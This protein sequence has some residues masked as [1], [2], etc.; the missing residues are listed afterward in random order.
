MKMAVEAE[1]YSQGLVST[2]APGGAASLTNPS[3][4]TVAAGSKASLAAHY[5]ASDGNW[6]AVLETLAAIAGVVVVDMGEIGQESAY[7]RLDLSMTSVDDAPDGKTAQE[8]IYGFRFF[9]KADA[10]ADGDPTVIVV[11]EKLFTGLTYTF[12]TAPNLAAYSPQV[13]GA[14]QSLAKSVADPATLG[15]GRYLAATGGAVDIKTYPAVG[16][17]SSPAGYTLYDR[18]PWR[19]FIRAC[20]KGASGPV[21]GFYPTHARWR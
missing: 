17:T 18:G 2:V 20:A 8:D 21:A 13:L 4:I 10:G 19:G 14:V 6:G 11:V 15:T 7:S 3:P 5:V 1:R 9:N 16:A 12:G